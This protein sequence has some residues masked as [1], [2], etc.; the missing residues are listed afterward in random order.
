MTSPKSSPTA[1]STHS[2]SPVIARAGSMHPPPTPICSRTIPRPRLHASV[3]PGRERHDDLPI[4]H[5][6][7]PILKSLGTSKMA[8]SQP[9]LSGTIEADDDGPSATTT[10]FPSGN[11]GDGPN[12]ARPRAEPVVL[13]PGTAAQAEAGIVSVAGVLGGRS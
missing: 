3:A 10:N 13:V 2:R 11:I 9:L 12:A 6:N 1:R 7:P 4:S 5:F 8:A